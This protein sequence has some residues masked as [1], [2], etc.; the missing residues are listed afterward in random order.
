MGRQRVL[1]AVCLHAGHPLLYSMELL[2][3]YEQQVP[4]GVF[5]EVL[6]SQQVSI[7]SAAIIFEAAISPA[8]I[9][10]SDG[11]VS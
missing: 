7:G 8:L 10:T 5:F 11:I 9:M 1:R 3:V 4:E 6:S 2:N